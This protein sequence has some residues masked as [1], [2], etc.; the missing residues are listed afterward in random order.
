MSTELTVT[1]SD[2]PTYSGYGTPSNFS[3]NVANDYTSSLSSY[4]QLGSE[5]TLLRSPSSLSAYGYPPVEP[6]SYGSYGYTGTNNFGS[7]YNYGTY[8]GFLRNTG[9][10]SSSVSTIHHTGPI[11]HAGRPA[12]WQQPSVEVLPTKVNEYDAFQPGMLPPF[13]KH[14]IPATSDEDQLARQNEYNAA[15]PETRAPTVTKF[16]IPA[17]SGEGAMLDPREYSHP[18]GLPRQF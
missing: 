15:R 12:Q 1:D 5:G 14:D 2:E 9:Y 18:A 17:T 3:H 10:P 7:S 4:P 13:K 6:P 16:D 11:Q 8:G